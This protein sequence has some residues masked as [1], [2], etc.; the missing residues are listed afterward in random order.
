MTDG[1]DGETGKK[2]LVGHVRATEKGTATFTAKT[3][4][5]VC[6]G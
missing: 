5:Y 6:N 3:H 4:E 2:Q 1:K